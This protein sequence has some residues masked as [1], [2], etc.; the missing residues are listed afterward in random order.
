MLNQ[1]PGVSIFGVL[2]A[3]GP[4]WQKLYLGESMRKS[5]ENIRAVAAN[6]LSKLLSL[7]NYPLL[8]MARRVELSNSGY[9]N[10]AAL[11]A[12]EFS[13]CYNDSR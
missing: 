10:A 12:N 9:F 1:V 2:C 3:L 6:Q 8:E 11:I 7:Y 4:L 13:I 5:T